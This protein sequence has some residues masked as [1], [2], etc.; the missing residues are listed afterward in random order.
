MPKVLAIDPGCTISAYIEWDG[1]TIYNKA[2]DPNEDV[3]KF[4]KTSDANILLIEQITCYGMTVG[5]SIFDTVFWSGRFAQ[6]WEETGKDT[7]LIPRPEIKE[8][9]CGTTYSNDSGV[10]SALILKYGKLKGIKSHLW[11]ALAV[12]TFYTENLE[13]EQRLVG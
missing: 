1:K 8:H 13:V 7:I 5:Q 9:H 6:A 12:A 11:S 2:I 3:L 10:R 4:V